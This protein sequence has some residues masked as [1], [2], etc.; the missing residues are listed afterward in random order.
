L[1]GAALLFLAAV[2]W[3]FAFAPQKLT[4]VSLP[5]LTAT[6]FRFLLAAPL[7][8]LV[9]WKRLKAP[10]LPLRHAITLGLV[11]YV[12][13]ALQTAALTMT[14]VARVALITGLYAVFVPLISPLF[15]H[16]RPSLLHW[17]GALIAFIGVAGL[18]GVVGD[19]RALATP[20]NM[21]DLLTLLHALLGAVQVAL[22]G[23]IARK[24]DAFA[25]N[26][27]QLIVLALVSV[28]IALIVEGVPRVDVVMEPRTLASFAYLAAFSTVVAFTAQIVGQRHASPS[29]AAV[30]MLLE[31]PVG[32]L[33][34]LALFDESMS[35]SQWIGAAVLI[36]GVV[37]SL[38][39]E[40]RRER[41][42]AAALAS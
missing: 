3:G 21:G 8:T 25:L 11:L 27:Q 38:Y 14:P 17:V 26:A 10:G 4:V 5:P 42:I 16:A 33:A 19:S 23:K 35:T 2:I 34:A 40:V 29:T 41:A 9:A 28:P 18:V 1:F 30:I 15:G 12:A 22:V 13:Y 32:V 39:A 7:I 20:L 36:A 31:T 6:A 24:A 37:T